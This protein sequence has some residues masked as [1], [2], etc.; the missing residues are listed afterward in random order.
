MSHHDDVRR[1]RLHPVIAVVLS[2]S[3]L[4]GCASVPTDGAI[5]RGPLVGPTDDAG[6]I[7]V[8]AR[9]PQPDASPL[10]IVRGFL[11]A[12]AG[13]TDLNVARE[14]LAPA[15][16]SRWDPAASISVVR[17]VL[18]VDELED[19][20]I[21]ISGPLDGIIDRRSRWSVAAPDEFI[22]AVISLDRVDGQWRITDVPDGLILSRTAADR[23]LRT[24]DLHFFDP[25]F[26]ALVPDPIVVPALGRGLATTL[27]RRLLEGPSDWLAPAVATAFPEGTRLAFESVPVV[28]GVA[29]VELT[30]QVLGAD[31]N[32]RRALSAQM[33]R[34]LATVAGIT[35]VRI[36]VAG[37]PLSIPGVGALQ[38]IGDWAQFADRATGP[39][40]A[41]GLLDGSVVSFPAVPDAAVEQVMTFDERLGE[42]DIDSR[43][44]I[45]GSVTERADAVVRGGAGADPAVIHRGTNLRSPQVVG[46][47]VW[48]VE[49][50]VGVL[51][52]GG[53]GATAVPV[54]DVDGRSL[55]AQ[56]SAV[57]VSR[58]GTR[59]VLV[60]RLEGRPRL[61]LARIEFVSGTAL[62]TGARRLNAI[63]GD[64]L[65]VAWSGGARLAVL[66]TSG[67]AGVRLVT[68]HLG[69]TPGDS[70]EVPVG[71]TRVAAGPGR[72][73]L[74]ARTDATGD[75]VFVRSAG[76][77]VVS[78]P[79]SQPTYP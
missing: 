69:L 42:F 75:E 49:R 48:V 44:E 43:G 7:R 39:Q 6:V 15:M 57:R 78:V 77:W 30:D 35:S 14:Y 53:R 34:T 9:P 36:T 33:V 11:A 20:V 21:S 64:V 3:L 62:L 12:N 50:G 32:T 41:F 27:V 74:V 13:L 37:T 72:A 58:D 29:Q 18:D 17:G 59:A 79:A 66:A 52:V 63:A 47:A 16:A 22:D 56:V 19:D 55:D 26:R 54:T 46:N 4:V 23:G 1:R 76:Q 51:S 8:I 38:S 40:S 25:Q 68:I 65:D 60:V 61:L 67:T 70:A 45:V 5:Q 73:L 31:A 24:Y 2:G 71:V 10:E 28:N